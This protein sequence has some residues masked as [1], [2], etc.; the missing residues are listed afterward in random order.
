MET[1]LLQKGL[2][3]IFCVGFGLLYLWMTWLCLRE[4]QIKPLNVFRVISCAAVVAILC[5]LLYK[6]LYKKE[7]R[8]QT[9]G[10]N[11]RDVMNL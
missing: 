3:K 11:N 4:P 2:Y 10:K 6:Y 7:Y 9:I 1:N 5:V 8:K